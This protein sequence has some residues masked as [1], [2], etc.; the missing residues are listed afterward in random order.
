MDKF[1][2]L[3]E[4]A[5]KLDP[6]NPTLFFNLGVVNLIRKKQRKQL[7]IIKKQLN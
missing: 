1:G 6:T 7:I 4:E 5:I 3:M 2:A